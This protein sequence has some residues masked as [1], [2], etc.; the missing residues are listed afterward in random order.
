MDSSSAEESEISDSE[1]FEYKEKPYGLLKSGELKVKGPHGCLR[2]PFCAGR[3]KQDYKYKDLLQH[4]TGAGKGTSNRRA[5]QKANHLALAQYLENDLA[6]EIEQ[7]PQVQPPTPAAPQTDRNELL[8]VPWTGIIVNIVK[9]FE[10]GRCI[11]S[12]EYLMDKFYKYK[13]NEVVLFWDGGKLTG[14]AVV[15]FNNNWTGYRNC[16]EFEKLFESDHHSKKDWVSKKALSATHMYGW[17]ARADDYESVG[18]VGD[19]LRRTGELKT[20]SDIVDEEDRGRQDKIHNLAYE[21]DMKN[22]NLDDLK[23]KYNEKNMSLSRL[24]D[25]KDR[26]HHDFL[27]ET[28]RM[29]RMSRDHIQRVLAEQELLNSDLERKKKQLDSWSRELNKRETRTE[30][31][32]LKLDEEKNKNDVRNSS[33]Q[34]ASLEQKKADENVLRLVEEQQREKEEALKDILKLEREL[35]EKQK[36]EMEIQELKG[37]LEV[38]KHLGD[39]EALQSK[40]KELQEELEEKE[41]ERNDVETLNQT[42]L[43]KERQSNDELQEA[44]KKLIKGLEEILNG[45][46]TN[47]SVKRMGEID[48]KVFQQTCKGRFSPDEAEIK[49]LELCSLW[50][51]NMKNPEWHPFKIVSVEGNSQHKEIIDPNDEMLED[52]KKEWGNEIYEAVCKALLE[53]N[54]YNPSGRYV[55]SELWNTKEN[56]KATVKEVVG[57]IMKQLKTP[58]RRR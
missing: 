9:R 15:K 25:E 58:R 34:R 56:R 13:P 21:L 19:Y 47:I 39:D 45:P 27:E 48:G 55:V 28:R 44:R 43:T 46:R 57:Y 18:A 20:I 52:L 6:N 22:E 2:C 38:M 50:Q 17:F 42:L 30:L 41:D 12:E 11:F 40:M 23:I 54:E 7:A 37:K 29:Q 4:A 26:L 8:C 3:K 24:L 5:K 16:L 10:N 1:I 53:M 14:E 31:D 33:L 51:E 49:A 32:R 36:L 35:D